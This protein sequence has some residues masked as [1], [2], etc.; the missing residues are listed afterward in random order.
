MMKK[1]AKNRHSMASRTDGLAGETD[2]RKTM[3]EGQAAAL[4]GSGGLPASLDHVRE[5]SRDAARQKPEHA[6]RPSA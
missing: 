4:A 1:A 6:E 5:L 3:A 2:P